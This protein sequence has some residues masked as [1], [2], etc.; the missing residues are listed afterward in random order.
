MATRVGVAEFLKKT[1]QLKKRDDKI[2]ALKHNDSYIIRTVLQGAFD[3]RIVWILPE[4]PVP[5][6]PNKLVD[7][8]NVFIR[9]ARLLKHFVDGG[10]PGLN[11]IKRETMFIELLENVAP[12]DAELLIALKDK[13]LPWKGLNADIVREAFPG[14]L[15]EENTVKTNEQV[16]KV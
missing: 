1:C 14:L 6:T 10:T 11:R 15:P 12:A 9:E 3:P 7:Q 2:A 4:G 5:Y 8:E 13:K 16:Q